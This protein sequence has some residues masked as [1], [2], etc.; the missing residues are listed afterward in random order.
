M[1]N[2]EPLIKGDKIA[3]IAP[4]GNPK[5]QKDIEEIS[6]LISEAGYFAVHSDNILVQDNKD[7]IEDIEKY[8]SD[9]SIKVILTL[10]GGFSCN[11]ILEKINYDVIKN[12]PK[13]FMG[14]SDITNLLIAFYKKS[15]LKTIHGPI[16]SEKKYL[17]KIFEIYKKCI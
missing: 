1:I 12:N 11:E 8:F 16:F 4:S 14:F 13:I 3:L 9:K 6:K 15:E 7:K 2:I 10:K 17:D 5:S